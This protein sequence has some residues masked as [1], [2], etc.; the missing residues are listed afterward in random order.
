MRRGYGGCAPLEQGQGG[1]GKSYVLPPKLHLATPI[2]VV[3]FE[4][5]IVE[6]R[7]CEIRRSWLEVWDVPRSSHGKY[8]PTYK[9][10]TVHHRDVQHGIP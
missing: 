2:R 1:E 3:G 6:A 9:L 7:Q 5:S 10:I 8:A 4:S